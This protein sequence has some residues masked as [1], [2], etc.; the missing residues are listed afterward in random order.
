MTLELKGSALEYYVLAS[1]S[2]GDLYGA[3]ILQ[4][5]PSYLTVNQADLYEVLTKLETDGKITKTFVQKNDFTRYNVCSIT[6]NGREYL[7]TLL[8]KI[9]LP[10]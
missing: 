6:P 9:K 5:I 4:K 3:Q 1:L 10:R 2:M 8:K 7:K